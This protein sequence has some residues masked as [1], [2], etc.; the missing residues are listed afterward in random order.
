LSTCD[1]FIGISRSQLP[2]H[3]P[4]SVWEILRAQ[5]E[6][7]I[8]LY[9]RWSHY[10]FLLG[11]N[12]QERGFYEIEA[13]EQGWTLRELKR[14]FNSGLYERLALSRDHQAIRELG[15]TSIKGNLWRFR[16]PEAAYAD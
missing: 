10:V 13:A 8:P 4:D 1:A 7:T 5:R 2:H 16:S 3:P 11:L 6:R 9:L 15:V 14:Q 12:E